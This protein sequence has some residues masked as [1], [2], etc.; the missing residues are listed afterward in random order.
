M[1]ELHHIVLRSHLS[2]TFGICVL[3]GRSTDAVNAASSV[4][5]IGICHNHFK[6]EETMKGLL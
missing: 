3:V 4:Y 6:H 2:P 5:R 1:L